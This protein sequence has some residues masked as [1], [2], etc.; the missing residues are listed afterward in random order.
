[1]AVDNRQPTLTHE[2]IRPTDEEID[3]AVGAA[4]GAIADTV[5]FLHDH[6]EL[7]HEEHACAAHL[8][9]SLG[10]AGLDVQ[11]GWAGMATALRA[12]L[13]GGR[14]GATVG[15]VLVYDAVPAHADDG[16]LLPNHSCGHGVLAAGVVGA[17]HALAQLRDQLSGRVVVLGCPADEIHAPHTAERGGGKARAVASG[18]CDDLDA[19]L[20]A[21]PE[22]INTVWE[23]SR[24]MSRERARTVSA[25]SLRPGEGQHASAMIRSAL[26]ASAAE[27]GDIVIEQIQSE[28]DVEEGCRMVTTVTF[29]VFADDEQ[30][31]ERATARLRESVP[32]AQ[33]SSLGQVY[34]GI[35][36][37]P[38]VAAAAI[39]ALRG[40]GGAVVESPPALPFATDFGNITRRVPGALIGVGR[41]GGWAF[42]TENGAREFAS[43]A[44]LESA[45]AIAAVLARAAARLT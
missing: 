39:E 23:R 14:E 41:N 35:R 13:V 2:S 27:P 1:L 17:A 15:L 38:V 37:D 32:A 36:P 40:T 22:Y 44:G 45:R 3:A 4:G 8:A 10:A 21:H 16:S 19:V 43:P 42:H 20:Y 11:P 5:E 9:L 6:P 30:A 28:G 7:G 25:R 24:W 18:A 12:E 33:W 34:A 31:L 26:D 29:L